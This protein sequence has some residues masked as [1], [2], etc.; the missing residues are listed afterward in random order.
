MKAVL[1][2][3]LTRLEVRATDPK[4]ERQRLHNV[5][6]VPAKGARVVVA[7]RVRAP[8]APTAERAVTAA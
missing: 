1:K 3:V 7:D 8:A 4:P 6:L 5:T 2:E